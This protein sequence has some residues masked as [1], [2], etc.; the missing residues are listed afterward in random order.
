LE[1]RELT[2]DDFEPPRLFPR[3]VVVRDLPL[4]ADFFDER[5]EDFFA[6]G[7]PW[8]GSTKTSEKVR[9]KE[10]SVEIAFSLGSDT[11]VIELPSYP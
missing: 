10:R 2:L 3:A 8:A 11:T 4:A 5:A 6:F 1:E 9:I 7:L